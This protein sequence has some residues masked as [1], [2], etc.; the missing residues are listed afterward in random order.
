M[1]KSNLT[2]LDDC[3]EN[4]LILDD[5]YSQLQ[6]M[7]GAYKLTKRIL[8]KTPKL[9]EDLSDK[10]WDCK[11]TLFDTFLLQF[12]YKKTLDKF[13]DIPFYLIDYS[14]FESADNLLDFIALSF[15]NE[16]FEK[17]EMEKYY[18][19]LDMEGMILADM[20]NELS[21]RVKNRLQLFGINSDV[22]RIYPAF[23]EKPKIDNRLYFHDFVLTEIDNKRYLIDLSYSQ[24]FIASDNQ[25][26][27]LGIQSYYQPLPGIYMLQDES[28]IKTA[29]TLLEKGW[30][31]ATDENMKNYFDGFALS[32]RNGLYY[33]ALGRVDYTTPYTA[34]D[35]ENFLYTSDSQF[36]REERFFLGTQIRKSFVPEFDYTSGTVMY[37]EKGKKLIRA[38]ALACQK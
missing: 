16:Y 22:L 18:G 27:S 28:R 30:I 25:L 32:F 20:C 3:I 10:L 31:D 23:S 6:A 24:F 26:E 2:R 33:Q 35:Y 9:C 21:E 15:R 37:E 38:G 12:S 14:K 34:S 7:N 11:M 8:S 5:A 36:E 13:G 4:I 29:R 17:E 19:I 1:G